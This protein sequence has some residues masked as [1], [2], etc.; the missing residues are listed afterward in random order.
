M[1]KYI[2]EVTVTEGNDEWWEKLEQE[3]KTGCDE[4]KAIIEEV[5]HPDYSGLCNVEVKL[6]KFEGE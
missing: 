1:K 5:M 6:K 2:F 4:V 3:G